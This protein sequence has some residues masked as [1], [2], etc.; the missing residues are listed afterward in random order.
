MSKQYSKLA[1]IFL[2]ECMCGRGEFCEV[3][4]PESSF[5][6]AKEQFLSIPEFKSIYDKKRQRRAN[7]HVITSSWTMKKFIHS[8]VKNMV[9]LAEQKV[10][11][12][13]KE[14]E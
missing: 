7:K 1:D 4:D 5:N 9:K 13:L 11:R 3:C 10:S 8:Y 14:V 12:L 2:A 6:V